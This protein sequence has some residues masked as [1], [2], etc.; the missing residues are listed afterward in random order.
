MRPKGLS[1]NLTA[2][3]ETDFS[4]GTMGLSRFPAQMARRRRSVLETLMDLSYGVI[5]RSHHNGFS[6]LMGPFQVAPDRTPAERN[7]KRKRNSGC[8][9][10]A[11][12][13]RW[14]IHD[15]ESRSGVGMINVYIPTPLRSYTNRLALVQSNGRTLGELIEGL[16]ARYGGL[17]RSV[18]GDDDCIREN[19]QIFV[20]RDRIFD[21]TQPVTMTDEVQIICAFGAHGRSMTPR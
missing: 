6:H 8:H 15:H 9:I 1:S 2:L 10:A 7:R 11:G 18:I 5:L 21:L 12:L 3:P 13:Q 14:S 19:I 16:E 20:N 17:R 4:N